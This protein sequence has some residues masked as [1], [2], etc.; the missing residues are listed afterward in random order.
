MSA[1][2]LC[3]NTE[4]MNIDF[5]N[6]IEMLTALP[7]DND[8]RQYL[9]LKRW[10][11]IP[12]C[13][14]C[15]AQD[16][17]HYKLNVKG[18]F[19]GMYKCRSCKQRFTVLLGTM[20][21]GSPIPLRK[22]F[23]ATYIFSAHKKGVS[24]HQLARDLGVTQR[25]AWFM[26][27]RLRET[28]TEDMDT[29]IG[30]DG[31]IVEADSTL[32]GGKAKNMSKSKRREFK[33]N[34]AAAMANKTVITAYLERGGKVRFDVLDPGETEKQLLDKHVDEGSFL[35]TDDTHVYNEV[36]EQKFSGHEKVN[37]TR[38]EY[39]RDGYIHT[40][41]I[42]GAFSWFDRMVI[43]TYHSIDRKHTQA[44]ANEMA[45]RYNNRKITDKM[46]FDMSLERVE[47]CKL[48]YSVLIAK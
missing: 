24:S 38:S 42:E 48:P 31:V 1:L 16:E 29:P 43:G 15:G 41:T 32:S 19:K 39:V 4:D 33:G 21:E 35:M 18:E 36:A 3:Y 7:T 46:R 5:K 28:F 44:Y 9:E 2:S 14:H 22:W 34:H 13:S 8:C 27:H 23:I 40:N 30:G 47:G 20:Y 17:K 45:Y 10:G 11:S 25:T 6:Y 12:L 26:L 37:H